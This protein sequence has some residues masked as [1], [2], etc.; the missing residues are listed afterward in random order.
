MFSDEIFK[1]MIIFFIICILL[2][3]VFGAGLMWT[4]PKIWEWVKPLL[5][6][7]TA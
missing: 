1:G 6:A 3:I 7:A 2:A 5:H 4:F